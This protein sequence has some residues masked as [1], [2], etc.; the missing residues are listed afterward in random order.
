MQD[1]QCHDLHFVPGRLRVRVTGLKGSEERARSLEL[2]LSAE[3]G[4]RFVRA[5]SI[6]GNV[7]VRYDSNATDKD[8]I[9]RSLEDLGHLPV[10]VPRKNTEPTDG[11]AVLVTIGTI[12]G[13]NVAK[14]ALGRA[15]GPA[16]AL[17]LDL[18]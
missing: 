6:T 8:E 18:L 16:A 4:I 5:N 7:V 11:K 12:V 15:V 13:K 3:P 17:V 14:A 1:N 2:L 10:R 9:L